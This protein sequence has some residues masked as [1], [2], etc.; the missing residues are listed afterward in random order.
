MVEKVRALRPLI[1]V[2]GTSQVLRSYRSALRRHQE[3]LKGVAW[4][5]RIVFGKSASDF[6][7]LS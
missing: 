5:Q 1:C 2:T 3:Y 7:L 4:M 6:A